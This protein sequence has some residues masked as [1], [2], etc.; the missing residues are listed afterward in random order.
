MQGALCKV[1]RRSYK[2][3]G[4]LHGAQ[5]EFL[6][7]YGEQVAVAAR[8]E[9][10]QQEL[11]A[12]GED[13]ERMSVLLDELQARLPSVEHRLIPI[14]PP[15]PPPPPEQYVMSTYSGAVRPCL[16]EAF[17]GFRSILDI[18]TLDNKAMIPLYTQSG[19]LW[20]LQ[21][22]QARAA[23]LDIALL[24][25]KIDQMMP[26]LGFTADDNDRLVASY[27]RDTR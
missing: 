13:M 18:V 27:R 14:P 12:C 10:I 6:S 9:A 22:M 20:A 19:V 3:K 15:P 11:E 16:I 23:D 21:D 7:A 24:D 17:C 25:K 1:C 5:E 2:C 4:R 8:Q 26:E